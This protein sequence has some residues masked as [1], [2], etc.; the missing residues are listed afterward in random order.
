MKK[1]LL[2]I[3]LLL[4]FVLVSC[5]EN[6]L[7]QKR[8]ELEEAKTAMVELQE[9]ID[10]LE[11]EIAELDTT[12]KVENAVLISVADVGS[13]PFL[14]KVK[15]RGSVASRRNVEISA[16]TAGRIQNI[17]V[18]EGQNVN[19][20]QVLITLDAAVLRNSVAELETSIEHAST[21]FEK[22]ERLWKKNIGTEIQYLTAKNNKESLENKLATLNAQLRMSVVRAP[23]SGRVDDLPAKV[24]EMAAPGQPLIRVVSPNAMYV[25]SQISER[26]LGAFNN[27]DSV[28]LHFPIQNKSIVSKVMSVGDVINPEN[29]TFSIEASLDKSEIKVKPNQVVMMEIADY[30]NHNAIV[31]PTE[32]ILAD[33][34]DQFL[35]VVGNEDNKLVARKRTIQLGQTHNGVTEI[36]EGLTT[37]DRIIIDGYRDVTDGATVKISDK[38]TQPTAQL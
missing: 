27:G 26:F 3:Q 23:F 36:L 24:G 6:N 38:S 15:F 35:Y 14:H 28:Q 30:Y 17:N 20:G 19:A 29:R 16:E 11:S 37:S 2:I 18:R 22:Q 9:S 32:L 21:V 12:T 25:E 7:D 34:Q 10:K 31:V 33:D 8:E 5:Q 13:K 4:I 1:N